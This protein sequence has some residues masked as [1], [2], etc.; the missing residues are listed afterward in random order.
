M[1]D[2][3]ERSGLHAVKSSRIDAP[4]VEEFP[5]TLEC[6]VVECQQTVYGFR[7]LGEIM[8]VLADEKVLDEKGKVIP[9]AERVLIERNRFY[10]VFGDCVRIF[11][12]QSDQT[13]VFVSVRHSLEREPND[14]R[15]IEPHAEF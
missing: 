6:K 10:L 5:L 14:R 1:E 11:G 15:C 13:D 2:K 8:N 7:V 9:E 4:I 12:V 3:F